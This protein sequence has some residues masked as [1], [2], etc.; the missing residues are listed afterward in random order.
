LDATTTTR[1]LKTANE[2]RSDTVCDIR[3]G[4][5]ALTKESEKD[6]SVPP[7]VRISDIKR[8]KVLL[9]DCVF[10]VTASGGVVGVV[11]VTT[12]SFNEFAGPGAASL[13]RRRVKDGEFFRFAGDL[14]TTGVRK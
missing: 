4:S 1:K 8:S 3:Q 2:A 6:P 12:E 7:S 11:Q 14:E 9:T 5:Q 10:A 13:A